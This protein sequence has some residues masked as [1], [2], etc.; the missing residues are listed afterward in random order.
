MTHPD[1]RGWLPALLDAP[2]RCA[3][4]L[5]HPPAPLGEARPDLDH[6]ASVARKS[7]RANGYLSVDPELRAFECAAGLVTFATSGRTAFIV[8]GP[9]TGGQPAHIPALLSSFVEAAR[10]SGYRQVLL[11]PVLG[12]ERDASLEAGFDTVPTGVEAFVDLQHLDFRGRAFADLRQMRNRARRRY[13]ASVAELSP[14]RDRAAMEQVY[15]RWLAERPAAHRM[16]LVVGKPAL[17]APRGRR[18]FGVSTPQGLQAFLSVVPCFDGSGWGVD[19]M[20]RPRAT[21]AGAMDLLIS[22]AALALRREGAR[23]FSL[24]ACPMALRGVPATPSHWLLRGIFW[25]LYRS[26]LG[27]RLFNFRSLHHYKRKFA[28]DWEPVYMAAWPRVSARALYVG[29]GMWGLFGAPWRIGAREH[30]PRGS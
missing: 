14:T 20:A 9:H 10:A 12:T 13:G 19:V 2:G 16:T 27:N 11:F 26:F 30:E 25:Y 3:Q 6:V 5:V 7:R 18:Y 8:G 15:A 1:R 17:D 28:P 29:C 4:G 23:V 22:D 24:G 21:P